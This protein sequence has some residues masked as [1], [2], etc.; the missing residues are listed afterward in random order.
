MH[1]SLASRC[2]DDSDPVFENERTEILAGRHVDY[3]RQ[4]ERR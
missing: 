2:G 3:I 4:V 1:D